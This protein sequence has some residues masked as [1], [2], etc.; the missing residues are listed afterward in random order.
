MEYIWSIHTRIDLAVDKYR[1][2]LLVHGLAKTRPDT[3]TKVPVCIEI[4]P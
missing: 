2:V 3:D 4:C 1:L